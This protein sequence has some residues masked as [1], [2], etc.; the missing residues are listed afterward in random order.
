MNAI[1]QPIRSVFRRRGTKHRLDVAAV[2]AFSILTHLRPDTHCCAPGQVTRRVILVA[3]GR[4]GT[5]DK[6]RLS[7]ALRFAVIRFPPLPPLSGS[8][9]SRRP[10]TAE[11]RS[12]GSAS[13]LPA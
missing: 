8:V 12:S 7:Q 9:A 6:V 5:T 13:P 11:D 10:L 4:T 1:E 3:G 2:L